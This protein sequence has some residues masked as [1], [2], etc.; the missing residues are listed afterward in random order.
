M[1]SLYWIE[2]G[3]QYL[4]FAQFHDG[5]YQAIEEYRFIS[6]DPSF[7]TNLISGKSL[8]EQIGIIIKRRLAFLE[9][10]LEQKRA[11]KQR[12]DAW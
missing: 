3:K 11:E 7:S 10:E 2:P 5:F 6:L 8:D 4:I 12:L 9:Q 1:Q